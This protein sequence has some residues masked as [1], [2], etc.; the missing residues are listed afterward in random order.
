MI[1][2]QA[3]D[4]GDCRLFDDVGAVVFPAYPTFDDGSIYT[5]VQKGV[6]GHECQ[7]AEVY[8]LGR[9][10]GRQAS[11]PRCIFQTVPCLEEVFRKQLFGK[12]LIVELYPLSH[13][14]QMRRR[15]QPDLAKA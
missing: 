13:E 14:S 9:N 3:R 8:R 12:G 15:V 7:E 5:F 10:I 11:P 6:E 2:P 4:T 1:D